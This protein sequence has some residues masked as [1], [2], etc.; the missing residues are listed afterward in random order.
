[1]QKWNPEKQAYEPYTP[2]PGRVTLYESDMDQPINCA[3]C[4]RKLTFGEGYSSQ[5]IH[6][7]IGLGYSVC[8]S[9]HVA[10]MAAAL[11]ASEGH[12]DGQN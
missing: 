3:A 1:M 5:Q 9:C 10:E 11:K 12:N 8:E 2:T 4:G 6:N 7:S